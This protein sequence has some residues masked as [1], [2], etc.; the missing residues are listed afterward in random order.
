MGKKTSVTKVQ[1][2]SKRVIKE[3][4]GHLERSFDSSLEGSKM[5]LKAKAS[6]SASFKDDWSSIS[7]VAESYKTVNKYESEEKVAMYV[8]T[9]QV[10]GGKETTISIDGK[11][12]TH[13]VDVH[14]GVRV[15][16]ENTINDLGTLNKWQKKA[17]NDIMSM[18][19]PVNGLNYIEFYFIIIE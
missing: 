12:A 14:L 2:T 9:T 17:W 19:P 13:T 3:N 8:N 11:V 18:E 16:N 5:I 4:S 1:E 10:Y 7:D 15:M 6:F